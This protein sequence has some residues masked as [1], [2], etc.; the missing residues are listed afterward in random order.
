MDTHTEVP[1]DDDGAHSTDPIA[2]TLAAEYQAAKERIKEHFKIAD[3][4]PPTPTTASTPSTAPS[5]YVSDEMCHKAVALRTALM[6]MATEAEE[7]AQEGA[8]PFYER[9]APYG[10]THGRVKTTDKMPIGE[11][12]AYCSLAHTVC[13]TPSFVWRGERPRAAPGCSRPRSSTAPSRPATGTAPPTWPWSPRSTTPF[14]L[15]ASSSSPA[16]PQVAA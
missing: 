15:E 3:G 12:A 13:P 8:Q 16:Q 5:L 9:V 4:L 7:A 10:R 2:P 1:G 14:P 6:L 11:L